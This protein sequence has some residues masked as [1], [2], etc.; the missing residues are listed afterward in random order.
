MADRDVNSACELLA[1]GSEFAQ[2]HSSE[3]TRG[4]FLLSKCMV[5]PC[6]RAVCIWVIKILRPSY[7]RTLLV[8]Y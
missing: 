8:N 2:L 7:L 1:M 5:R 3:Y 4:L 6:P